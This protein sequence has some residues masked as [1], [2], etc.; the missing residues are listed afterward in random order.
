MMYV[1]NLNSIN[2]ILHKKKKKKVYEKMNS[3]RQVR[4]L[5]YDITLYCAYNT[6][7]VVSS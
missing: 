1:L 7:A 6:V 2:K 5:F 3:K 4:I